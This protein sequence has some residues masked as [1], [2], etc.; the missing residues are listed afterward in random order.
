MAGNAKLHALESVACRR[1][2]RNERNVETPARHREILHRVGHAMRELVRGEA[3]LGRQR[4]SQRAVALPGFRRAAR[5][6]RL[7]RRF[8]QRQQAGVGVGE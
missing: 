4:L 8:G 3:A 1:R 5:E 7:V 6:D 2:F